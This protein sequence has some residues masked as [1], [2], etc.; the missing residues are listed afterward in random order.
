MSTEPLRIT[1]AEAIRQAKALIDAFGWPTYSPMQALRAIERKM[2]P[3]DTQVAL[4]W[5]ICTREA[6][7][8]RKEDVSRITYLHPIVD[9]HVDE[10]QTKAGIDEFMLDCV[11][12][13]EH[14]PLNGITQEGT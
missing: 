6:R 1:A 5:A 14:H 12:H 2:P 11:D 9:I 13:A 3:A 10:G 4:M 8:R 7:K